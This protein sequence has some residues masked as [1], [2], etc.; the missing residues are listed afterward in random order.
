VIGTP[1]PR[2]ELMQ[3]AGD[4]KA[5]MEF[6]RERTYALNPNASGKA[7]LGFEFEEKHGGKPRGN[8]RERY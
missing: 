4:T 7:E 8:L 2:E 3:F 6:L 5:M 1:I